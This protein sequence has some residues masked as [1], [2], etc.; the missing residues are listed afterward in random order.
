MAARAA[1]TIFLPLPPD[2][3]SSSS[4]EEENDGWDAGT[5]VAKDGS[6]AGAGA[7]AV[8]KP[9]AGPAESFFVLPKLSGSDSLSCFIGATADSGLGVAMATG[10]HGNSFEVKVGES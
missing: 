6:L 1:N 7:A 10:C 4:R 5:L 9:N 2:G 8:P 3:S